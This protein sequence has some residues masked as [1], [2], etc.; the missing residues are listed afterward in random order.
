MST[1][2]RRTVAWGVLA[3]AVAG[4]VAIV[5]SASRDGLTYYGTPSELVDHSAVQ[6]DVR[7]GGMVVPGTVEQADRAASFV[8]TDGATDVTVRYT[9]SLPST[10]REGEGAVVEGT[11]AGRELEARTVLLR[12]SNEYRAPEAAP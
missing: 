3:A 6:R 12:H 8:L 11:L 10:V 7:L 4:V 9:G 2:R 5:A 1:A